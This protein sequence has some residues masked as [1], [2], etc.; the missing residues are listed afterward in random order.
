[1][2]SYRVVPE[3]QRNNI[4]FLTRELPTFTVT[5]ELDSEYQFAVLGVTLRI[6]AGDGAA[7]HVGCVDVEV[8]PELQQ[9]NKSML[10]WLLVRS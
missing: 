2:D 5:R 7:T 1:M 3:D 10:A 9:E 8:T 6:V 4:T